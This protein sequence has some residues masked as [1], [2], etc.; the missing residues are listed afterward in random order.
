MEKESSIVTATDRKQ[1]L[2][3]L[4]R[5]RKAVVSHL[6]VLKVQLQ[7]FL[8][9]PGEIWLDVVSVNEVSQLPKLPPPNAS[10]LVAFGDDQ[11]E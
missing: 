9:G 3:T 7:V 4:K 5:N 11:S 2:D 6:L 8:H 1:N 10:L